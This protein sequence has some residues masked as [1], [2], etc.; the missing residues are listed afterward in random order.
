MYWHSVGITKY[1]QHSTPLYQH[2]SGYIFSTFT[3]DLANASEWNKATCLAAH[4]RKLRR[5]CKKVQRLQLTCV[6]AVEALW[7]FENEKQTSAAASLSGSIYFADVCKLH[8]EIWWLKGWNQKRK[9]CFRPPTEDQSFPMRTRYFWIKETQGGSDSLEPP[10]TR[11]GEAGQSPSKEKTSA[12]RTGWQ[13][14]CFHA[15]TS[16]WRLVS[17]YAQSSRCELKA[18]RL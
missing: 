10:L 9:S 15:N 18:A 12:Q 11:F 7:L 2:S 6:E 3:Q 4:L 14:E 1:K 5:K 8:R 16:R 17:T 13:E